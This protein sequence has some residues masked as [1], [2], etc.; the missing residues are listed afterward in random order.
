MIQKIILTIEQK[1]FF[2]Q[3]KKIQKNAHAREIK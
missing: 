3:K 1:I 2:E